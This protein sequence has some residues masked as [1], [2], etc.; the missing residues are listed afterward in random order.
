M[1]PD[2]IQQEGPAKPYLCYIRRPDKAISDLTVLACREEDLEDALD[3]AAEGWPA[4]TRIDVY[5]GDRRVLTRHAP[6]A[7]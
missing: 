2:P 1:I 6:A 4:Y 7:I 3:A 5:D